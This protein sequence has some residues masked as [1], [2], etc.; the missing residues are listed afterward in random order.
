MKNIDYCFVYF[1]GRLDKL[2]D[3]S[4]RPSEFYYGYQYSLEQGNKAEILE[5]ER[6]LNKTTPISIFTQKIL[7]IFQYFI[8]KVFKFQYDFSILYKKEHWKT[9]KNSKNVIITN[10]RIAHS[11]LPF[12][13]YNKVK[14]INTNTTVIAMGLLNSSSTNKI[15]LSV[16]HF[17][18]KI[19]LRNIDNIVFLGESEY[20]LAQTKFLKFKEKI[21]FIPF[22]IDTNFWHKKDYEY[23]KKDYVLFIGND[24]NRDFD[25]LELLINKNPDKDFIIVSENP[26]ASDIKTRNSKVIK[27]SWNKNILDDTFLRKLYANAKVTIVPLNDSIQPSGQSVT[28]QSMSMQTPVIITKTEGFWKKDDFLHLENIYF[29]KD[30][31]LNEW[32]EAINS[33]FEDS[34]LHKHIATNAHKLVLNKFDVNMFNKKL[35]E[36]K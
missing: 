27:G 3:K 17:L 15:I 10:N 7:F 24:S 19:M 30:N 8:L 35:F 13:I 12:L 11:L 36:L 16:H 32:S 21:N 18:H 29:I 26:T 33:M 34:S 20:K 6:T 1:N 4:N 14:N 28:L 25:F 31:N 9:L 23:E 5:F 2:S 22:G